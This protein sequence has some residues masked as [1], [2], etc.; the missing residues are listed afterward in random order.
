[1]SNNLAPAAFL[2]VNAALGFSL[3]HKNMLELTNG[4]LLSVGP[5]IFFGLI[6]WVS[7]RMLSD[8]EKKPPA[9]G[10]L[11]PAYTGVTFLMSALL[12]MMFASFSMGIVLAWLYS[13]LR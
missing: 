8:M 6:T 13:V 4:L 11:V 2:I 7:F 5:A 3:I 9:D 12:G 10:S 1:M